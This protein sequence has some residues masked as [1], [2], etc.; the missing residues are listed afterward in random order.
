MTPYPLTAYKTPMPAGEVWNVVVGVV[1]TVAL[2]IAWGVFR[3]LR[4]YGKDR[5]SQVMSGRNGSYKLMRVAA[6]MGCGILAFLVI[7]GF[8][9]FVV[10]S[11]YPADVFLFLI[12]D[13]PLATAA[14]ILGWLALHGQKRQARAAVGFGCVTGL[15]FTI[16]AFVVLFFGPIILMERGIIP[17][18]G[19]GP[20]GAFLYAPAAFAVGTLGGVL[21]RTLRNREE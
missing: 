4:R 7:R 14:A 6:A 11:P 17:D 13:V 9:V 18:S 10:S 15:W 12:F 20:L 2:A 1:A 21:Y 19:Q 8:W 3:H 5:L 16:A